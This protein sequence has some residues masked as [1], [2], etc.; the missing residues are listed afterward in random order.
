MATDGVAFT[1]VEKQGFK[2]LIS[3]FDPKIVVPSARTIG[4]LLDKK[5]VDV[6]FVFIPNAFGIF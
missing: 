2:D 6:S 1:T 3:V 4:R 5:S